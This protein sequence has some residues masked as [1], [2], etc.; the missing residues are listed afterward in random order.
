MSYIFYIILL[1]FFGALF[2]EFLVF[3]EEFILITSVLLFLGASYNT[4]VSFLIGFLAERSDL[5]RKNFK[6]FFQN[7]I[8][9]LKIMLGTY[10]RISNVNSE[11]VKVVSTLAISLQEAKKS[12][13]EEVTYFFNY[14]VNAQLNSILL[15]ELNLIKVAYLKRLNLFFSSILVDWR[16]FEVRNALTYS[17]LLYVENFYELESASKLI[18]LRKSSLLPLTILSRSSVNNFNAFTNLENLYNFLGLRDN[19]LYFYFIFIYLV[20]LS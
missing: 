3:D 2:G 1:L 15:E 18:S 16:L 12:R 6:L 20:S 4:I 8:L 9:T 5:I 14:A 10:E 13:S 17:D 19:F 7:K 11:L